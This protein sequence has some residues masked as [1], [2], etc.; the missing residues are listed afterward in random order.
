[1]AFSGCVLL[2][3]LSAFDEM[4]DSEQDEGADERHQ[5]ARRLVRPIVADGTADEGAEEGAGDAD[6]HCDDNAAGILTGHD[7][8]CDSADN[9]TDE[10]SPEQTEHRVFSIVFIPGDAGLDLMCDSILRRTGY[11]DVELH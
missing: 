10:S 3:R 4:V 8:L 11:G 6:E 2:D 1:M 5:E 9:Q 7:E